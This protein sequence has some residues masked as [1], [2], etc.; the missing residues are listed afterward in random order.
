MVSLDFDI[1]RV[2]SPSSGVRENLPR[3]IIPKFFLL[4]HLE[5]TPIS[6]KVTVGIRLGRKLQN[7]F[8]LI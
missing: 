6:L 5:P 1:F 8:F 2:V 4:T 7:I 3:N